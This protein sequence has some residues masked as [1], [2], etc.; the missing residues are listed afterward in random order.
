MP[1]GG[2]PSPR[3]T[4]ETDSHASDG[5]AHGPRPTGCGGHTGR[6]ESSAPTKQN[7]NRAKRDVVPQ[8]HLFHCAPLQDGVPYGMVR[9]AWERDGENAVPCIIFTA[10]SAW[11][12]C[13][14]TDTTSSTQARQRASSGASTMTR[15]SGSVPDSR[16]R[17][18]PV[19]PRRRATPSTAFCTDVAGLLAAQ[20]AAVFAHVLV[21][22]LVAHGGLGVA[23]AQPVEGAVQA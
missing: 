13:F 5:G 12:L 7:K 1:Q 21:D 17:M 4:R 20:R 16:T 2:V 3:R 14:M 9:G 19:S 18:R 11:P 22:V 23:D 10:Y 8:G 6:T 15:S